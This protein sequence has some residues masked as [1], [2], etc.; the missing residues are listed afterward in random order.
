LPSNLEP[1]LTSNERLTASRADPRPAGHTHARHRPSVKGNPKAHG[2]CMYDPRCARGVTRKMDGCIVI[3]RGATHRARP[4]ILHR[5]HKSEPECVSIIKI[6]RATLAQH[7]ESRLEFVRL[8]G[9]VMRHSRQPCHADCTRDG[10]YNQ[11]DYQLDAE[12]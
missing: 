8:Y 7:Q 2:M 9:T 6:T 11:T 3:A 10:K 5:A 12:F 1:A 4:C